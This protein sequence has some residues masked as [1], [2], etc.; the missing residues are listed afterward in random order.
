MEPRI[1]G[2]DVLAAGRRVKLLRRRV[3]FTGSTFEK[4]VVEFGEAAIVV[5]IL[6]DGR[7][8]MVKQWR[9]P[10]KSWVLE[11]PAGRVEKGE[12]PEAAARRELVEETGFEPGELVKV[13]EFYATPGYSDEIMHFYVARGLI[14]R[15]PRPEAGEV[16][17]VVEVDPDEYLSNLGGEILD[18]KTVAALLLCK[19]YGWLS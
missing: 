10:V 5:P 9:A 19:S 3:E 17:K 13:A 16:V 12:E 11:V 15:A 14:E 18:L 7:V 2:D 8:V 1:L 6:E 4:D